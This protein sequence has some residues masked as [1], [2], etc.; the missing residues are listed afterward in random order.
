MVLVVADCNGLGRLCRVGS[1]D[2]PSGS[3]KILRENMKMVDLINV[4]LAIGSVILPL[5]LA[6]IIIDRSCRRTKRR[7]N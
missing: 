5:F 7:D 6:K 3:A 1:Q 4:A 2:I